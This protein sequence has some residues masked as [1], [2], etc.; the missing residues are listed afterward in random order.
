VR[1]PISEETQEQQFWNDDESVDEDWVG[2]V[3]A[4][5]EKTS[6]HRQS[7]LPTKYNRSM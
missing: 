4:V 2:G 3:G 1:A 7:S 5:D 6:L